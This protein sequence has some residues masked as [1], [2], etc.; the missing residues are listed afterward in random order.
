MSHLPPPP[1][2]LEA[3]EARLRQDLAWLELPPRPWVPERRRHGQQLLDVA[4]IGGGMAGLAAATALRLSGV[5]AQV[6]DR[7]GPGREGP[8]LDY[9]RMRTLRSPKQLTGPALGLP[10]LTFRAWYE[11]RFGTQAWEALDKIPRTQWMDY[12][13]WYRKVMQVPVANH[14]ELLGLRGED[15]LLALRLR[16]AGGE[17]ELFARRLVLATGRDA[18]GGAVIPDFCSGL[19][20]RLWAHS[21][22]P[23]DFAALRGRRV[24][25]IGAGASAMDNAACALEA[26]AAELDLF[27][28]R[29]RMPT[30]NKGKGG[31]G[32]GNFLGYAG[33]PD[34]WKWRFQHYVNQQQVPPPR[35]STLRVSRH[36]NARFH[37]ASPVLELCEEDGELLLR[38]PKGEYRL[39]FLIV[40]TG[41]GVDLAQRPELAALAPHIRL[42]KH[43]FPTP[44]GQDDAELENSPDLGL[45]FAFQQREPGACPWLARVH[46]FNYPAALSLGKLS[47][48]IP[49]ISVGAWRLAH[50]LAG[51]FYA[52]DR[53]QHFAALQ[54][55]EEP[56]L[57]GDEWTD[58]DA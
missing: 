46:C 7:S 53:E 15:D 20:R 5:R 8:W 55:Y 9:A 32:P 57:F 22:E 29:A 12:L 35:D 39:D 49:G 44:P 31:S 58:A 47:G 48:D 3:L 26:G 10:A 2:N 23:I 17:R 42:W 34:A 56:E 33:L 19:S 40:G 6:F 43:R 21:A 18:L 11:A 38:T 4:V 25:V 1:T 51:H 28:R 52:E 16:D 36:A 54:A 27:V 13:V 14:T 41:F 24:G 45:D 37:F 30:I 50:A